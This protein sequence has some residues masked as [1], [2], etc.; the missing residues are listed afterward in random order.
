MNNETPE[1]ALRSRI[2]DL[3]QQLKLSDEGCSRLA[4]R[5]LD[6]EKEVQSYLAAHPQREMHTDSPTLL[7]PLLYFDAGFGFSERDTLTAPDYVC[8]ELT[9]T[10]TATFELPTAAQALR[11]DPGELPCCITNFVFSDD[12]ILCRPVNGVPLHGDGIL[13]LNDDPNLSFSDDRLLCVPANGLTLPGDSILFLGDDPNFRLE[14]LTHYPAGMKLVVS[15]CYFPLET[16]TDEPLFNAVLEGVQHFQKTWNSE[17]RHIQQLEQTNAE[18]QQT[19]DALHKNIAELHQANAELTA[20]CQAYEKS[21]EGVL[22]SSSWRITSPFRRL[23][24]WF[25]RSR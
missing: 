22:S 4:A 3:E 25:H 9:G 17:A 8:D 13:F 12:R 18:Q 1:A 15:Y 23:L 10:V 6:L 2:A 20:R 7:Q 14:G 24:G 11:F 5:C 16:L 21:L 19:V